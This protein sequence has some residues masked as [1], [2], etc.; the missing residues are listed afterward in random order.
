LFDLLTEDL[1]G[2]GTSETILGFEYR[3]YFFFRKEVILFRFDPLL[4]P[5]L[6]RGEAK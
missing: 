4:G 2:R 6:K 3:E 1:I 5:C